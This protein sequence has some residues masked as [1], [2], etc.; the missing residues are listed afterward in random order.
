MATAAVHTLGAAA[1]DSG[2][3]YFLPPQKLLAG[4]PRQ[5]VWLQYADTPGRFMAGIWHSER[6]RWKILYTEQEYCRMLEGVSIITDQA[7]VSLTL[8]PGDECIIPPGFSGTWEVL[9]PTRKRFVI[10]EPGQPP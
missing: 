1:A 5:T 3:E 9:E 10:Y 2:E 8:R 4:N 6:G 7:G